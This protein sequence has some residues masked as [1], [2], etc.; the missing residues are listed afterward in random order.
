VKTP[1][2]RA[3]RRDRI[4]SE[5]GGFTLIEV[6]VVLAIVSV[7]I[8]ITT[9]S[10]RAFT[11]GRRLRTAGDGLK[12]LCLFARDISSTDGEDY[13]IV[14]DFETQRYWLAMATS[15]DYND[16]R[17]SVGIGAYGPEQETTTDTSAASTS[18]STSAAS[19]ATTESGEIV[20]NPRVAGILGQAR[21]FGQGIELVQLDVDR[22]GSVTS[23]MSDAGYV[24]FFANG[25]AEPASIYLINT[26]GQGVVVDV[27][28]V[29]A[30]TRSRILTD[31]E[32]AVAGIEEAMS[33]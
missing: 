4:R 33:R 29:A 21:S 16:L 12:S 26:M 25:T 5:G 13:I 3:R 9:P 10:M 31:E 6:L 28:L 30:Q 8:T 2:Q 11:E 20:L 15:L 7:L 17:Q 22:D 23:I 18:A 19:T 24:E 14:L 32:L 27:P 1:V